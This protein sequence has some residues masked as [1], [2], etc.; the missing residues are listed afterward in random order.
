MPRG[1]VVKWLNTE[2][3]KTSIHRFE[4][5]RRL[6]RLTHEM[7]PPGPIFHVRLPGVGHSPRS[8]DPLQVSVCRS[9]AVGV[10]ARRSRRPRDPRPPLR[11]MPHVDQIRH[12]RRVARQERW[13]SRADPRPCRHH[14]KPVSV[15]H[16]PSRRRPRHREGLHAMTDS[17]LIRF[18][19]A[20]D[21]VPDDVRRQAGRQRCASNAAGPSGR[22][23]AAGDRP[24]DA[25]SAGRG[26]STPRRY[27]RTAAL[28]A[29]PSRMRRRRAGSDGFT[30]LLQTG[31][32][33]VLADARADHRATQG[34]AAPAS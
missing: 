9:D 16:P 31:D 6:H 17:D 32:L 5:D 30:Y 19:T 27:V 2:V 24:C 23:R 13:P 15:R 3:C 29:T 26:A 21:A 10:M 7:G 14:A 4:S 11:D 20:I 8:Q 12:I 1:D 25:A 18:R 33:P 22:V 28:R 34:P